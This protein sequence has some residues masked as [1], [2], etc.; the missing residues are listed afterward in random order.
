MKVGNITKSN[1]KGQIVIPKEMRDALGIDSASSL[2]MI[3]TGKGIYIYPV[4]EVLAKVENES[5]YLKLLEKTKGS[6]ATEDLDKLG[7]ARSAIE[8]RASNSRKTQ[9]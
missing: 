2:N 6:W 1:N 5:S 4:E 9:W 3:A 8:L 7:E